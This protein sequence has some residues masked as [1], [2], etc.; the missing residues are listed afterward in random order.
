[1]IILHSA[2]KPTGLKQELRLPLPRSSDCLRGFTGVWWVT[3]SRASLSL[4]P[5]CAIDW[6]ELRARVLLDSSLGCV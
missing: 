3:E 6:L 1:M 5:M 2:N 4:F